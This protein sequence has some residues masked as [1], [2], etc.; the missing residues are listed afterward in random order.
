MWYKI[1]DGKISFVTS[2]NLIDYINTILPC[3]HVNMFQRCFTLERRSTGKTRK[4][5][6]RVFQWNTSG[7]VVVVHSGLAEGAIIKKIRPTFFGLNLLY[8]S[9]L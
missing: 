3:N 9:Q 7:C 5:I 8:I 6:E 4:K 2:C 1:S